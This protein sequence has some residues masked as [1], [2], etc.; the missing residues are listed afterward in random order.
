M[1]YNSDR[2]HYVFFSRSN[3]AKDAMRRGIRSFETMEVPVGQGA[4]TWEQRRDGPGIEY[5]LSYAEDKDWVAWVE[6]TELEIPILIVSC[7]IEEIE[8]I[9]PDLFGIRPITP[10]LWEELPQGRR[11]TRGARLLPLSDKPEQERSPAPSGERKPRAV[12]TKAIVRQV[13]L[14]LPGA[15]R[16]EIIRESMA[17]GVPEET[18][19][20][21]YYHVRRDLGLN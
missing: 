6:L 11:R 13:F 3:A 12:G 4:W 19:K 2:P 8:D 21:L 18:A 7:L 9:I 14:D 16:A 5:A 17:R 10:E 1:T 15:D 20:P